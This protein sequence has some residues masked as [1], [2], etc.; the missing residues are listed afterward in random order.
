MLKEHIRRKGVKRVSS[1]L[2][3]TF[4]RTWQERLTETEKRKKE[5]LE[6][7]KVSSVYIPSIS[8]AVYSMDTLLPPENRGSASQQ[9]TPQPGQLE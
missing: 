3:T 7:L 9:S 6:E 2:Y 1:I 4:C 5:E 8:G